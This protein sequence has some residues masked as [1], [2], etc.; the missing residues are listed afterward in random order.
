M[1]GLMVLF[2]PPL[3]LEELSRLNRDILKV[4]PG[5]RPVW[6]AANDQK[7]VMTPSEAIKAGATALVI[8][9]PITNPPKEIGTSVEAVRRIFDEISSAL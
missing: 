7:R 6:A 4:T 9:R 8:G 2:A 3:E 1:L 5:V